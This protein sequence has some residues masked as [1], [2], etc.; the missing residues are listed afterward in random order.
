[1][2]NAGAALHNDPFGLPG[3]PMGGVGGGKG[4]RMS[5]PQSANMSNRN[6]AQQVKNRN[7]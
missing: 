7:I 1:M 6:L 2:P 4:P 3:G 5:M